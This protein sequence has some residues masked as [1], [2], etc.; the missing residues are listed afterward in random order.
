MLLRQIALP[1]NCTANKQVQ[2]YALQ[3]C[4]KPC[5]LTGGSSHFMPCSH[6]V[7]CMF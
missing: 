7:A 4:I 2:G 5:K 3:S 6:G 1:Q